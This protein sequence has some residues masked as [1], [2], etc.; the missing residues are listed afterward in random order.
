MNASGLYEELQIQ[1]RFIHETLKQE[2]TL[3]RDTLNQGMIRF[4]QKV[5]TMYQKEETVVSG[6]DA[7]V[8]YDTY[9]FPLDLTALLAREKT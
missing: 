7:F 4:E 2:E 5:K 3:F 9:G 1:D 6:K 8:L